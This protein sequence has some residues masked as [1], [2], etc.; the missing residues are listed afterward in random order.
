[1]RVRSSMDRSRAWIP[2][3]VTPDTGRDV[4]I[5]V[6]PRVQSQNGTLRLQG[7]QIEPQVA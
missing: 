7:S 1:M 6:C 3:N 4:A 2:L 5:K